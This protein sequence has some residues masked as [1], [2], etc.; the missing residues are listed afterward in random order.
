MNGT[1]DGTK[2]DSNKSIIFLVVSTLAI[3][4]TIGVAT[5]AYCIIFEKKPDV[6]LF[7]AFVAI[8]NYILGVISGSLIKSSPTASTTTEPAKLS[9]EIKVPEQTL[10]TTT[11]P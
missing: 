10:D 2:P 4:A 1:G 3:N 8:V 5:L 11:R 9:G 7:T 6:G